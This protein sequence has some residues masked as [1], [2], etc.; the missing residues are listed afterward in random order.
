M[1]LT[2]EFSIAANISGAVTEYSVYLNPS[3]EA[4]DTITMSSCMND[5]CK[6]LI[7]IPPCVSSMN[8]N[9]TVTAANVLGEGPSS[10]PA[11]IGKYMNVYHNTA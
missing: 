10:Q 7:K 9:V 6:K 1:Q 3:S 11:I 4:L 2:Q 8:I 5:A